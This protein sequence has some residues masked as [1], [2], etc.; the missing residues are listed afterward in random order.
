[1]L[2]ARS[3]GRRILILVPHPDDEVVGFCAAIGRARAEGA[4]VAVLFLTHGCVSR[5]TLWPWDRRRYDAIVGRRRTEAQ[6]AALTLGVTIAGVAKRPARTLW[7]QLPAA[8]AEARAAI[9]AWDADQLWAPAYEGGNPDHDGASALASRLAAEGLPVLEFAEYNFAG[10]CA[11]SQDFPSPNGTEITLTLSVTEQAAKRTAV[12]LYR[13]E[14]RNLFYVRCEREVFRPLTL[15]DYSRPAHPGKLWYARFQWVPF[16]H[17]D[18][19]FTDPAEVSAA[20]SAYLG[21]PGSD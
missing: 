2:N 11:R 21:A 10:G 3:F 13:S 4:E 12:G 19:D 8:E 18:V 17:P 14:R 6:A 20:L 5:E 16:R 9:A 7:R 15:Y 1:M